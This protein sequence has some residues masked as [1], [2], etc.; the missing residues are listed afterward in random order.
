MNLTALGTLYKWIHTCPQG[1]CMTSRVSEFPSSL[2]LNNITLSANTTF[3]LS[4]HLSTDSWVA[5]TFWLKWIMLLWTGVSKYLFEFVFISFGIY[6]EVEVQNHRV[7]LCLIFLRNQA[8]AFSF[9]LATNVTC[10]VAMP[11]VGKEQIRHRHCL[12]GFQANVSAVCC[13]SY[14]WW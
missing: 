14:F 7:I 5:S 2:R 10:Q 8:C 1:S 9:I 6:P 13:C 11:K 3:H 12:H 4:I